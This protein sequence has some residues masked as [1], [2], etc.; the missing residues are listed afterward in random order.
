LSSG[1][2]ISHGIRSSRG[3][4]LFRIEFRVAFGFGEF[5][6]L[7]REAVSRHH[8]ILEWSAFVS[9]VG[10]ERRIEQPGADDIMRLRSEIHR[11]N[12]LCVSVFFEELL[13]DQWCES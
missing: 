1:R 9:E 5:L 10:M 3:N 2:P 12:I 7:L 6:S 8:D 4:Q 11:K 13:I